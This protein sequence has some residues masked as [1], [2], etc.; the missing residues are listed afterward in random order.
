MT[1]SPA[2]QTTKPAPAPKVVKL[3][4]PAA[5]EAAFKKAYPNATVKTVSKEVEAGKTIYEVESIDNGRRRDL[6]YN[7][8]GSLVLYEEELKQA[9]VPTVVL[10]AI[11]KRYPKATMTQFERLYVI[12]DNSANFEIILKGA[13][14][15]EVV[16]TPEGTWVTPKLK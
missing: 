11:K 13:P 7:P 2:A 16:L 8:D 5:V 6:N 9:D 1:M 4:W 15:S 12:K 14:V 3:V 10:D